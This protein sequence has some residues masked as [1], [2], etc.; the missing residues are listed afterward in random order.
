MNVEGLSKHWHVVIYL[1]GLLFLSGMFYSESSAQSKQ[2]EEN[3][4]QLDDTEDNVK[5][6]DDRLIRIEEKQRHIQDD[7]KD[8]SDKLDEILKELR[9]R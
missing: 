4:D 2:I 8:N 7:V 3:A 1:A 6:I 9:E 5:E